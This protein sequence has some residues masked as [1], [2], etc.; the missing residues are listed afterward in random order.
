MSNGKTFRHFLLRI[1]NL[2]N[3]TYF[4][5]WALS[6][7]AMS[8]GREDGQAEFLEGTADNGGNDVKGHWLTREARERGLLLE[9]SVS[10]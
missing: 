1:Q 5:F 6:V 2:K 7:S 4:N 10:T 3:G 8:G 9:I